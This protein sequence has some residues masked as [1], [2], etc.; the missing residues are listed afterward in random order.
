MRLYATSLAFALPSSPHRPASAQGEDRD[1]NDCQSQDPAVPPARILAACEA[2]LRLDGLAPS[3]SPPI[4]TAAVSISR[5]RTG[6]ARSPITI[7]C[8]ADPAGGQRLVQSRH[9]PPGARRS[10]PRLRRL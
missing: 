2:L 1:W 8:C 6:A 4:S 3:S 5:R 7:A 10:C 9:R